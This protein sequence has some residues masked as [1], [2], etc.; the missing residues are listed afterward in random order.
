[1]LDG[2]LH[3]AQERRRDRVAVAF[4]SQDRHAMLEAQRFEDGFR[5]AERQTI[6]WRKDAR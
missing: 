6:D 1:L 5:D 2:N 4:V 3:L